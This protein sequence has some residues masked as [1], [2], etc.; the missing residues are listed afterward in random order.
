[1]AFTLFLNYHFFHTIVL[2]GAQIDELFVHNSLINQYV[3]I[4]CKKIIIEQEE[5]NHG[6]TQKTLTI[7]MV[8]WEAQKESQTIDHVF[9]SPFYI[10]FYDWILMKINT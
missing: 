7:N 8:L 2:L 9:Y 5:L 3:K 4:C 1:L 6:T 10:I